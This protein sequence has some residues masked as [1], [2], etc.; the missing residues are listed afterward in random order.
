MMLF[1]YEIRT[2]LFGY[3]I[4]PALSINEI[5]NIIWVRNKD[6]Y[7]S[8]SIYKNVI[9]VRDKTLF[10]FEIKPFL[11]GYEIRKYYLGMK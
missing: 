3:R 6:C 5:L 4:K 1:G 11:F 10:E 9:W 8:M 7:L 2:G